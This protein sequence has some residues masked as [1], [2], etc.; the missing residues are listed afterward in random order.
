MNADERKKHETPRN[1]GKVS[2]FRHM[3]NGTHAVCLG[4]DK[5]YKWGGDYYEQEDGSFVLGDPA[6]SC[7]F[8]PDG[9]TA[10]ELESKRERLQ[11]NTA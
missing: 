9:V 7:C 4:D 11:T 3:R 2:F 8:H 5:K 1:K 6:D 10:R